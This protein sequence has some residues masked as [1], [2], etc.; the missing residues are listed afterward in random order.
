MKLFSSRD[1][2]FFYGKIEGKIP[3]MCVFIW[4]E[5]GTFISWKIKC[6]GLSEIGVSFPLKLI[7]NHTINFPTWNWMLFKS[8]FRKSLTP[9]THSPSNM[10]KQNISLQ[11]V[12]RIILV[13][14]SNKTC[15]I[16]YF[17]KK[18]ILNLFNLKWKLIKIFHQ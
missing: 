9:V 15:W 4:G 16:F 17:R 13:C 14:S 10:S 11:F 6:L 8:S 1:F 3:V 2:V 5:K 7:S 18:K 12:Q